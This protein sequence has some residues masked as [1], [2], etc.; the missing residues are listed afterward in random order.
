MPAQLQD[1]VPSAA[2][3]Q[4]LVRTFIRLYQLLVDVHLVLYLYLA[5]SVEVGAVACRPTGATAG[6]LACHHICSLA[7]DGTHALA[8]CC[9]PLLLLQTQ[10][11]V[12]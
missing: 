3:H 11:S 12:R 4:L 6:P 5:Q 7:Q 9:R 2:G 8:C 10:V 1:K